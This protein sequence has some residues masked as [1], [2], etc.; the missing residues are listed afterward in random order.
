MKIEELRKLQQLP[1][2]EKIKFSKN[3][4]ID[5]Y[6]FLN[7]KVYVSFSGGKDST[8]LLHLV[9]S[10]YP[11]VEAVFI[12]TGLEYPMIR[13]FVKTIPNVTWIRP[14][15]SFYQVIQEEGYPIVSKEVATYIRQYRT[16]TDYVKHVRWYGKNGK[17]K[18]P[19][20]WKFLVNAPFK[21]SER[22]CDILKKQPVKEYERK[23]GKRPYLGLM[24]IDSKLRQ[25]LYLKYGCNVFNNVGKERSTPIGFWTTNDVWEYIRKY[26]VPYCKIYDY[27]VHGTGCI[28]CLFGYYRGRN[29]KRFEVLKQLYPKLYDYAMNTLGIVKVLEYIEKRGNT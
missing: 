3:K 8:V 23:T 7:G 11:D 29:D 15:K 24:A 17:Y 4:I 14:K 27:G 18:I 12:D 21:I 22:C 10:I 6:E 28:F 1:L 26:N 19:E 9:R 20:K 2:E 5:F 25:Y 16:S 13:D